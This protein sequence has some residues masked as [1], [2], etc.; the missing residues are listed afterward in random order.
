MSLALVYI[1]G[2]LDVSVMAE[3]RTDQDSHA[4]QCAVS[5]NSLYIVHDYDRLN[6]SGYDP[7]GSI[8]KDLCTISA[9]LAY[10]IHPDPARR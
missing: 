3:A 5:H 6:V 4:D 2:L 10:Y 8:A 9:A 1:L 7:S